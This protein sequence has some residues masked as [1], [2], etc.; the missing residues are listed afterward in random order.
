[1]L[2]QPHDVIDQVFG[3]YPHQFCVS[4]DFIFRGV[5]KRLDVLERSGFAGDVPPIPLIDVT[6]HP[7]FRCSG[8]FPLGI[9]DGL[10]RLLKGIVVGIRGAGQFEE[11]HI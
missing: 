6:E 1:M 4:D 10:V 3:G 11:L 8:Q 2:G 5:N 7:R 9:H